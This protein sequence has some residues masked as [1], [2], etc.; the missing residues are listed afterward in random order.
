MRVEGNLRGITGLHLPS[1][2]ANNA[3]SMLSP[4]VVDLP[5]DLLSD[6]TFLFLFFVWT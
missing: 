1:V 2:H 3:F 5:R 6:C 4:A